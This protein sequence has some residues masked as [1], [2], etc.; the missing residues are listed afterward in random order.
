MGLGKDIRKGFGLGIGG[1]VGYGLTTLA[2]RS[3]IAAG[4]LVLVLGAGRAGIVELAE[5]GGR[6]DDGMN[7]PMAVVYYSAQNVKDLYRGAMYVYE[8]TQDS[9]QPEPTGP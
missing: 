3:A 5:E 6:P 2:F 9:S 7:F 8:A 4:T 1:T